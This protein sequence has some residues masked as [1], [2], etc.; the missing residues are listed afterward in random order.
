MEEEILRAILDSISL[1]VIFF[2]GANT[3]SFF[4]QAAWEVM[5]LRDEEMMGRPVLDC[6]PSH[7][8]RKLLSAIEGFRHKRKKRFRM[9]NVE[10]SK[11][12]FYNNTYSGVFGPADEYLGLMLVS[13]EVTGK[14]RSVDL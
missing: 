14:N 5:G 10:M 3:A 9:M 13:E 8:H 11:G 4:N 2:D 1:S 12:R 7:T 6:H